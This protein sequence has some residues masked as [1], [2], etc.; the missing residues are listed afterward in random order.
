MAPRRS[1]AY[2][3]DQRGFDEVYI[4]GCGGIGQSYPGTSCG[5]APGNKYFNPALLHNRVFEKTTGYCTDLFFGQALKWI[6]QKRKGHAPFFVYLTPNCPHA[7]LDCPPEYLKRYADA[8]FQG[9]PLPESVAKFYGMI[10]N[11]D[12]NFAKLIAK[13]KEWDLEKNTLVIFQTD[14]GGTAGVKVN[15]AGMRG[16]KNTP[17]Q[18]GTPC[19]VALALARRHPAQHRYRH[20]GRSHRRV[21]DLRRNRRRQDS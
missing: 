21:P 15:N 16:M 4:H 6:D 9:K 14:N 10:T 3:P 11:I 13:V 2:Q 5:N 18:G 7:P 8:K 19:A 20:A 17:Y 12:D 1:G